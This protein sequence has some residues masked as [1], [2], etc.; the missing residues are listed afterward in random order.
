[1]VDG[2]AHGSRK[3]TAGLVMESGPE[4]QRPL[5]GCAARARRIRREEL[6]I[7]ADLG[8]GHWRN[9][10]LHLRRR[11]IDGARRAGSRGKAATLLS[12]RQPATHAAVDS[13]GGIAIRVGHA[14]SCGRSRV[15]D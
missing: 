15:V 3:M 14:C 9:Q 6:N 13:L 1:M 12:R 8:V 4:G 11:L 7:G 2:C 10:G 5:A